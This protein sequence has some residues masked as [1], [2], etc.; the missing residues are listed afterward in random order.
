MVYDRP[1]ECSVKL[2]TSV[3]A[4]FLLAPA[5]L[6]AAGDPYAGLDLDINQVI[7]RDPTVAASYPTSPSGIN[8]RLGD[9]IFKNIAAEIA[10]SQSDGYS[11]TTTNNATGATMSNRLALRSLQLDSYAFL[12]LGSSW[13]Q[14]FLTAGLAYDEANARLRTVTQGINGK[15][16]DILTATSTPL[17]GFGTKGIAQELDWRAGFGMELV[18][19]DDFSVRFTAR[20]SPYT[21]AGN[22]SGGVTFGIGLNVGL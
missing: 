15:G 8:L 14:P 16:V 2:L 11:A 9:R 5:S 13:F 6:A 4:F 12:P 7:W 3:C 1:W 19:M 20:Y 22:M 21:F 18:P 10:Y 17:P